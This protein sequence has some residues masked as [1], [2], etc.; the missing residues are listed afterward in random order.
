MAG[1]GLKTLVDYISFRKTD[2]RAYNKAIF[3]SLR[4]WKLLKDYD[5]STNHF[6]T[7]KPDV[8]QFEAW[9]SILAQRFIVN[10]S[11]NSDSI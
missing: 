11:Q 4:A 5:R 9:R 1:W 2:I 3:Y 6:R 7:K 8:E 10:F